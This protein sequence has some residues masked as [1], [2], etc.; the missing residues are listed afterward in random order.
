MCVCVDMC[1]E[2]YCL[3]CDVPSGR[4]ACELSVHFWTRSGPESVVVLPYISFPVSQTPAP[5]VAQYPHPE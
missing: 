1:Y 2:E 4:T 3:P 5:T